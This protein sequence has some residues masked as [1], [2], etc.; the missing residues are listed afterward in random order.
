MSELDRSVMFAAHVD[1][2]GW[3][4][5]DTERRGEVRSIIANVLCLSFLLSGC[6]PVVVTV[7]VTATPEPAR[8]TP[9]KWSPTQ[10]TLQEQ[11]LPSPE[12]MV[13][14][15]LQ[16]TV[17]DPRYDPSQSVLREFLP[18]LEIESDAGSLTYTL[19]RA[20][21]NVDDF[22]SLGFDLMLFSAVI[23]DGS[24]ILGSPLTQIKVVSPGEMNSVAT[25]SVTGRQNITGIASGETSLVDAMQSDIDWGDIPQSG[26]TTT[27]ACGET[28]S[29]AG[30]SVTCRIE[31][32]YCSYHPDIKGEPTFCNDYR[33]PNNDFTLLV[34]G[35]DWSDY[36]GRCLEVTGFVSRY[37]GKPQIEAV[38]R[39]QVSLCN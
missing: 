5:R 23:A 2:R 24:G 32:A 31:R 29:L 17:D 37:E 35:Q 6:S 7:V 19:L 28:G 9:T 8:A 26:Q 4:A 21:E 10:V 30:Q 38:S 20:P 36:D 3:L 22:I 33:Y 15:A 14:L 16:D 12:E 25:L 1:K 39:S 34:W 11:G 13:L 18:Y 27:M